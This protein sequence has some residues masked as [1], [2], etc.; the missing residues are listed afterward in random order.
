MPKA[1]KEHVVSEKKW[2]FIT[3]IDP[4]KRQLGIDK[5]GLEILSLMVRPHHNNASI[6]REI[7][8][9][10]STVQRRTRKLIQ[11]GFVKPGNEPNFY[12]LGFRKALIIVSLDIADPAAICNKLVEIDGVLEA[13]AYLGAVEVLATAIFVDTRRMMDIITQIR[14]IDGVKNTEWA[15][16]V[17]SVPGP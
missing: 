17:Y 12:A 15:E 5:L 13:S 16:R 3:Q 6:A 10:L 9:P 11:D 2:S 1:D 4:K 7:R 14:R 8:K